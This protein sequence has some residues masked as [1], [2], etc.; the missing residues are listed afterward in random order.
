MSQALHSERLFLLPEK[1][2]FHALVYMPAK[3]VSIAVPKKT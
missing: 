1:A 3:R 2:R